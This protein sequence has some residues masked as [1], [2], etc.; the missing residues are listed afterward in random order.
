MGAKYSELFSDTMEALN[1]AL[2]NMGRQWY[3]HQLNVASCSI[4]QARNMAQR[5]AKMELYGDPDLCI[6]QSKL[7]Q[8]STDIKEVTVMLKDMDYSDMNISVILLLIIEDQLTSDELYEMY[9]L[10]STLSKQRKFNKGE[11]GITLIRHNEFLFRNI[12]NKSI[13]ANVQTDRLLDSTSLDLAITNTVTSNQALLEQHEHVKQQCEHFLR[14]KTE[15]PFLPSHPVVETDNVQN[16]LKR[17]KHTQHRTVEPA[18][19]QS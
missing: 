17:S 4:Q 15:T 19:Q 14:D 5:G 2:V 6:I 11:V 10:Y 7:Q 9:R 13:N 18:L 8:Y 1:D 3:T 16:E 12:V